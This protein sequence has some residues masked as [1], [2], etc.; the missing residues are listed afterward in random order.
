M[1]TI[2]DNDEDWM[3]IIHI[4]NKEILTGSN[5]KAFILSD[6]DRS[7]WNAVIYYL[8]ILSA[9]LSRH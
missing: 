4:G 1:K 7:I 5:I 3:E 2:K 6:K 9:R 8:N